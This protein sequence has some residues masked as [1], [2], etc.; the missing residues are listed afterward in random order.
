MNTKKIGVIVGSLRK[1]SYSGQIAEILKELAPQSLKLENII[2]GDLEFYNEDLDDGTP[3]ESWQ[4]FRK[5]AAGFDGFLFVTPEYN[6]SYPSVI[7][8]A[9]D[10][11]SR[12]RN[13]S[14]WN[15]KP[16]AVVSVS[17]GG[18]GGF[19]ANHHLRQALVFLNTPVMGQPEAYLG[20][21]TSF[22]D[23]NGK[24]TNKDTEKFLRLIMESFEKWVYTISK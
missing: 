1:G 12:P 16:V 19:G 18:I 8:N 3:P 20:N 15:G 9:L 13:G 24:L 21:V 17:P 7:K 6:R 14:V 11:G 10:I 23:E 2:I 5:E 4:R 22:L